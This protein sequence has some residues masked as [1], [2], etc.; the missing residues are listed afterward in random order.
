MNELSMFEIFEKM[1]EVDRLRFFYTVYGSGLPIEI[2]NYIKDYIE[3]KS[4]LE[5]VR[6]SLSHSLLPSKTIVFNL[7]SSM[8]TLMNKSKEIVQKY[9][10]EDTRN[11]ESLLKEIAENVRYL[12]LTDRKYDERVARILNLALEIDS[13]IRPR[14]DA[15]VIRYLLSADV[16]FKAMLTDFAKSIAGAS[17][18]PPTIE[19]FEQRSR[20]TERRKSVEKSIE[21]E[22]E[23][24]I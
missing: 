3:F 24:E 21:E 10:N 16:Y 4:N 19:E 13:L 14:I 7:L 8:R 12:T 17:I 18:P 11:F 5:T 23:E 2:K 1:N 22:F 20:I 9:S 15:F 6:V